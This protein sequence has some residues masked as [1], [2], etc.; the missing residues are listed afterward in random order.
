MAALLKAQLGMNIGLSANIKIGYDNAG[1]KAPLSAGLGILVGL[2]Q[3]KYFIGTYL[4]NRYH[5][6]IFQQLPHQTLG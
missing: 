6:R 3:L 4:Y 1:I 5:L 2:Y